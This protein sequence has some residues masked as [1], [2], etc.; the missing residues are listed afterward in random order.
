MRGRPIKELIR[1]LNPIIRGYG[2]YW[3]YVVSKKRRLDIW[4]ITYFSK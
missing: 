3:K 4:I 1:V 2:Q